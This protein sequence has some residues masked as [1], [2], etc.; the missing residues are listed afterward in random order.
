MVDAGND[1]WSGISDGPIQIEKRDSDQGVTGRRACRE[2]SDL[3]QC[4]SI[5]TPQACGDSAGFRVPRPSP[6]T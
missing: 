4:A 3:T 6:V 2:V 1:A 5:S